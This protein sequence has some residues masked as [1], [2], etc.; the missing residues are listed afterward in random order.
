ML[1]GSSER[2]VAIRLGDEIGALPMPA[3]VVPELVAL[4]RNSPG[5]G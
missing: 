1:A 3:E 5:N 4:V 2:Q